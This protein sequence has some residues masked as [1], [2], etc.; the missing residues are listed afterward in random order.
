LFGRVIVWL[1]VNVSEE[2]NASI[3]RAEGATIQ[4]ISIYTRGK[5]SEFGELF[6][7]TYRLKI[8]ALKYIRITLSIAET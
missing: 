7:V 8:Y 3:F 1:F 5:N 4:K 6:V 2:H